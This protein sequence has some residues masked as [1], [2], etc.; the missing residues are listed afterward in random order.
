M[1]FWKATSR[2]LITMNQLYS[3]LPNTHKFSSWVSC[4]NLKTTPVQREVIQL[5]M[6]R[7]LPLCRVRRELALSGAQAAARLLKTIPI[8]SYSMD[9]ICQSLHV[10]LIAD[11]MAEP[12][13]GSTTVDMLRALPEDEAAFYAA[14]ANVLETAGISQSVKKELEQRFGF[15][16][17]EQDEY[18]K[19]LNRTDIPEDMWGFAAESEVRAWAG[20][21][22]VRKK[23]PQWLRKLIMACPANYLF[24]DVRERGDHGIGGA[25]AI[26]GL[27]STEED[28]EMA[29]MDESNAFSVI[30]T[31]QWMWYYFAT[32]MV[33]ASSVWGRLSTVQREQF[34]PWQW[35]APIYK[36]LPMGC[37]HSVH[38]IMSINLARVGRVLL[39]SFRLNDDWDKQAEEVEESAIVRKL[40]RTRKPKRKARTKNQEDLHSPFAFRERARR[41]KSALTPIWVVLLC[42]AGSRRQ[43]D[44]EDWLY[45]LAE[46]VGAMVLVESVDLAFNQEWDLGDARTVAL[47]LEMA[48]EGLLDFVLGGP[49]CATWSM[50]RYLP[51]GPRPLRFRDGEEWGRKDL[52]LR[53]RLQVDEA[54]L[55]MVNFIA[56]CEAVAS[57]GGFYILEHPADPNA[58]PYAS[59]FST[60][61]LL[62]FLKRTKGI[63]QVIDQCMYGGLTR[64]ATG[65]AHNFANLA[66]G[67]LR[68]CGGHKHGISHGLNAQGVFHTRRLQ[69]YPSELCHWFA[70]LMVGQMLL[71][72]K[73]GREVSRKL[74]AM[75]STRWK[76]T[77]LQDQGCQIASMNA[78]FGNKEPTWI[79]PG[80]PAVYVHVDDGVVFATKKGQPSADKVMHTMADG[81]EELGFE[82]SDRV[83]AEQ[84]RKAIGFQFAK[85]PD[86]LCLPGDK[87][88]LLQLTI[89][90]LL[91]APIVDTALLKSVV[92]IWIWAA[93][94]ARNQLAIPENVFQFLQCH[95]PRRAKWW[96]T[97]KKEL[98][99]MASMVP[100]LEHRLHRET[101]PVVFA[102]D[103]EGVN[104]SDAG[105]FGVVAAPFEIDTVMKTIM[106]S[107]RPA[108]TVAK[109]DGSIGHLK[110]P[111]KELKG[112]IP[113]SRVPREV[114]DP[115]IHWEPLAAGRWKHG[116]HITL[117]EGRGTIVLLKKIA[118]AARSQHRIFASLCDNFPWVGATNKGRSPA[119]Q[120][121]Q[122]LRRRT[123]LETSRDMKVI[124]PWTDTKQMPADFLSRLK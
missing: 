103:A 5:A 39:E 55:L 89:E 50:V 43:G 60:A 31:P 13:P 11:R 115:S 113:V 116:D 97:A 58:A 73:Y 91:E 90:W 48:A 4:Q 23:D 47:L 1:D 38:I 18:V 123:A 70:W 46:Q 24:R 78:N 124:H 85:G 102:T 106:V 74:A 105:G 42:F 22:T 51:G 44:V 68:C 118:M 28:N 122:L 110:D 71:W 56:I 108:F 66:E 20:V 95:F 99:W 9:K 25:A 10:P 53:E 36:R 12:K 120:V 100:A 84:S 63:I 80:K 26:S 49:P 37:S 121:N 101:W 16:G 2:Y 40:E 14:E 77:A 82:V 96:N 112:R 98:R 17:G 61:L 62:E 117:G 76:W 57:M 59:I 41:A 29:I 30:R 21:S 35:I 104:G 65:L 32:P 75:R 6:H 81:L 52:T 67:A 7:C 8:E 27:Q 86:R 34:S 107:A 15:L 19:Y 111:V 64:K 79:R 92:G 72:Q 33:L 93:S 88:V 83:E 45:K 119:H 109:L 87:A 3:Q 69:S 54:N 114:L 94:L